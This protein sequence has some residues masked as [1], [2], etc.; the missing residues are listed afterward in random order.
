MMVL[1]AE[2]FVEM[3]II[4]LVQTQ[5]TLQL[6]ESLEFQALTFL[7]LIDFKIWTEYADLHCWRWKAEKS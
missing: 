1:A 6:Q 3:W 2:G 5:C 4:W 7:P